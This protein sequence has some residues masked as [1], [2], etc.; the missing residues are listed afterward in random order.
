MIHSEEKYVLTRKPHKCHECNKEIP[1]HTK[2]YWFKA[3]AFRDSDVGRDEWQEFYVCP[4][5][6]RALNAPAEED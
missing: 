2:C 4:E 5:C 3:V 6:Q 1:T